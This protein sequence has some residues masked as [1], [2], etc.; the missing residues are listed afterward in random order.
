MIRTKTDKKKTYEILSGYL[1][2]NNHVNIEYLA[3]QIILISDNESRLYHERFNTRRKTRNI[4]INEL[5]FFI[6]TELKYSGYPGYYAT[7]KHVTDF[8]KEH[9]GDLEKVL[10]IVEE[11]IER[12]RK[13]CE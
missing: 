4:A 11:N 10:D 9:G 12:T 5:M 7:N 6:D 1:M 3:D 2:N 8:S 13:E